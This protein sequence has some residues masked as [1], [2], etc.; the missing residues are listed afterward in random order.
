MGLKE[1]LNT[2]ISDLFKK[3]SDIPTGSTDKGYLSDMPVCK[4][5]VCGNIDGLNHIDVLTVADCHGS[6][7][8][9][10]IGD[11]YLHSEAE[12]PFE[13]P[14]VV[15][16][17]GDNTYSDI[18]TVLSYI[19][20]RIPVFGILGNHDSKKLYDDFDRIHC[21]D[22]TTEDWNGFDLGGLSGSIRYKEGYDDYALI[23]DEESIEKMDKLPSC[24]ILI[25]HD[26][27]CFTD[28]VNVDFAHS[29]LLGIGKYIKDFKTKI[30][31][32]G[33]L[34]DRSIVK[35]K[36]TYIK[37]CYRVERFLIHI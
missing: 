33:H 11:A 22:G 15:F 16:L 31:L 24:D 17:L 2:D 23:S 5:D 36:E 12:D 32:H 8:Q 37:C 9:R 7:M 1:F 14:W 18:E 19:P 35:Y 10:E 30:V 6:L 3:K 20:T 27:P 29:G 25:T 21:L 4:A 34:H 26:K 13:H 28:K